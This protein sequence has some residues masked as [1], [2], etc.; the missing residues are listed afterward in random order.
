MSATN[1]PFQVMAGNPDK[2]APIKPAERSA[3][4]LIAIAFLVMAVISALDMLVYGIN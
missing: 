3:A 4:G 1:K 2:P